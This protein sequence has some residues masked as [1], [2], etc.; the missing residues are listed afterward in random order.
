MQIE[1]LTENDV[2]LLEEL[3]QARGPSGDEREVREVCH[4][5]L[6]PI[7]DETWD[8]AAGNLIGLVKATSPK[9]DPL[10]I[11]AHMDE[12]AMIVKRIEEDGTLKV[13]NL[14]GVRPMSFGQCAV[15]ILADKQHLTGALSLGSL[16]RTGKSAEM[17]H[18]RDHGVDWGDVFVLTGLTPEELGAAGVHP[19]TRV[20]LSR[21]ERHLVEVGKCLGAHFMDDRALLLSGIIAMRRLRERRSELNRDVYYVCSVKEEVTNSGAQFAAHSLPGNQMIA[22]EVGPVA[23]E[24]Q[25]W[26]TEQPIISFGDQKGLYSPDLIDEIRETMA[27]EGIR[28]QLALLEFFASDASASEA[29]G[30]KPQT[31]VI[32][33]PTQNTHGFEVIHK[34][35]IDTM[36]R[37]LVR[38]L[39]R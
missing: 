2:R 1:G 39:T 37:V 25:T 34:G 3:L 21:V 7:C 9:R 11:V 14:G 38:H 8:D 23:Q 32:C 30:L 22:I 24:Y 4:R 5:A 17:Q 16:H 6:E 29:S 26:L 10:S 13:T 36:A 33:I 18:I 20:V 27:M 19:G 35:A 28:P 12:I 31:A 15:D